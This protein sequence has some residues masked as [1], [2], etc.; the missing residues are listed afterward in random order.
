MIEPGTKNGEMRRGPRLAMYSTW[1]SSILGRPPMPE[2][3]IT[4]MRSAVGFGDFQAAVAQGLHPGSQAVMDEGIHLAGF[5]GRDIGADVEV[6]DF[7]GDVRGDGRGIETGDAA[8]ARTS[9][10]DIVPSGGQVVADRRH[11]TKASDDDSSLHG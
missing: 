9:V 2:P 5:L 4:P 11:D 3:T 8:D 1:V 10:D 7:A 6:L